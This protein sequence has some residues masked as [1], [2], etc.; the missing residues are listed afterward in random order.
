MQC[1][2]LS[3]RSRV[4]ASAVYWVGSNLTPVPSGWWIGNVSVFALHATDLRFATSRTPSILEFAFPIPNRR[5]QHGVDVYFHSPLTVPWSLVLNLVRPVSIS[6]DLRGIFSAI[7]T[8][9]DIPVPSRFLLLPFEI[10]PPLLI[11]PPFILQVLPDPSPSSSFRSLMSSLQFEMIVDGGK[12]G[13]SSISD[14][15]RLSIVWY[16]SLLRANQGSSVSAPDNILL[17]GRR[18]TTS[19]K[20]LDSPLC[21]AL[22]KKS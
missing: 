16:L 8:A 17:S 19:G 2:L 7:T 22:K 14:R 4:R 20:G 6:A 18:P 9:E 21:F 15:A 11:S 10:P 3:D 12:A 1:C 13:V 5:G